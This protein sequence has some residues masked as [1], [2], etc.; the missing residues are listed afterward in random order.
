MVNVSAGGRGRV[1]KFL[2]RSHSKL[3]RGGGR[4]SRTSFLDLAGIA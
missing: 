1:G 2:V 4:A 3:E